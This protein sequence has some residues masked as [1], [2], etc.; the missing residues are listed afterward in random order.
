MLAAT[1]G[2]DSPTWLFEVVL[3]SAST[4]PGVGEAL[5]AHALLVLHTA[6]DIAADPE[7]INAATPPEAIEL[8]LCLRGDPRL[9]V[10]LHELKCID[11][12]QGDIAQQLLQAVVTVAA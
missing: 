10:R 7:S 1:S 12:L 4:P 6:C 11:S 2:R 9:R 8:A 5:R 3:R